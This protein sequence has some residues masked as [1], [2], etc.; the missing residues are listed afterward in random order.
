M[1]QTKQA[2][3]YTHVQIDRPDIALNTKT[4]ILKGQQEL[5][6]CKNIGYEFYCEEVFMVKHKSK[7]SC[8][9]AIY[10][11]FGPDII[12]ENCNFAYYFN[13]TNITP[14]VLD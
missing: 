3:S 14:T 2:N 11:D 4:Y 7:Y 6:T 13:K 8:D 9:S 12:K 5:G 1:D 10:F